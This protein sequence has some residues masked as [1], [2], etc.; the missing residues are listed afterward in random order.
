M[1]KKQVK[2]KSSTPIKQH[3]AIDTPRFKEKA[4]QL[5]IIPKSP[6]IQTD[7]DYFSFG[8]IEHHKQQSKSNH[9][10]IDQEKQLNNSFI[11]DKKV[12]NSKAQKV[13]I[14]NNNYQI[15]NINQIEKKESIRSLQRQFQQILENQPQKKSVTPI[16]LNQ[17]NSPIQI[18][19]SKAS[20]YPSA[21][22]YFQRIKKPGQSTLLK[23]KF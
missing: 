23:K 11:K 20:A 10:F 18:S 21:N 3:S 2:S 6:K 9:E 19:T 7:S 1:K 13:Q 8:G 17:S 14:F 22:N 15:I 5:S 4:S 12:T 16:K